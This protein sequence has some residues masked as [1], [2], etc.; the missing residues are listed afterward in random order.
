MLFINNNNRAESSSSS[1]VSF[2]SASS[3]KCCGES[4][5]TGG[6]SKDTLGVLCGAEGRT[7][8][9]SDF[10]SAED[11][12]DNVL[13][14]AGCKEFFNS[15]PSILE[16]HHGLLLE[17]SPPPVYFISSPSTPVYP[18]V[19]TPGTPQE[20]DPDII[21]NLAIDLASDEEHRSIQFLQSKASSSIDSGSVCRTPSDTTKNVTFNPQVITVDTICEANYSPPKPTCAIK[22]TTGT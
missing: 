8:S 12:L 19:L 2:E 22:R 13:T 20:L 17:G 16:M 15:D 21:S 7:S 6:C 3:N 14:S 18:Q 1:S 11:I 10:Q 4:S 5:K 9:G